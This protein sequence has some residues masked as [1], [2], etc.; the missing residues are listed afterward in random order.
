LKLNF[1]FFCKIGFF[2]TTRRDKEKK[3]NK[4]GKKST[5]STKINKI[6]LKQHSHDESNGNNP[7][8][9]NYESNGF[10]SIPD[11]NDNYPPFSSNNNNVNILRNIYF[12]LIFF[13]I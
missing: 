4:T 10:M 11:N 8:N 7:Q 13:D 2:T 1:E 3:E 5:I 6:P 12:R 9:P